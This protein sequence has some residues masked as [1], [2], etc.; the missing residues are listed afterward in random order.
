MEGLKK[1]KGVAEN[2]KN[3]DITVNVVY[4]GKAIFR[5]GKDAKPGLLGV[6][7]D[8]EV[9]DLKKTAEILNAIF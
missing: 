7:G 2:L 1:V 4:Q 5:M 3:N 8:V 9:L 6:F